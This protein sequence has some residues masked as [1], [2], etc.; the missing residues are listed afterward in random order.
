MKTSS[1]SGMTL[2]EVLV[3]F[4][5]FVLMIMALVTLANTGLD[6][7]TAGESRK[8]A[9]DRAQ[10]VL[11][12]I[13]QDLR[14]AAGEN[15]IHVDGRNELMPMALLCDYDGNRAQR[16]RFV[17]GGDME[18]IQVQPDPNA[19]L[20]KR[21]PSMYYGDYWEIAYVM[22]TDGSKNTLYR[23][24][25][26]FDRRT[27]WTLLRD[28][29]V[30]KTSAEWF[31][32]YAMVL[33]K[34]VL[35]LGFKFWTQDTVTWNGTGTKY[36]TCG[37]APHRPMVQ[38]SAAGKCPICGKPTVERTVQE[39]E[40]PSAIW[41]STRKTEASFRYHKRRQDR[42]DP[43]FVYPE[44]VQVTLVMESHA[45]GLGGLKLTQPLGE[46]DMVIKVTDTTGLPD[47]PYFV[48]VGSEWIEFE[49][50]TFDEI[51]VR[52]RGARGTKAQPHAQGQDV[53][54]GDTFVTEVRLPVYRPA[55]FK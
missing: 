50:R 32:K 1:Q 53:R 13:S 22:D 25:R 14:N 21:T 3:A 34:G 20:K 33:E 7:W 15:V 55:T 54:F 8:D 41:D 47:P 36:H 35:Y 28:Q 40:S 16:I 6:T 4:V 52:R 9:Y 18:R 26:Y 44:I 11:D 31:Q 19:P 38:R 49:D 5:I 51:K 12:Q 2:I 24:I 23:A 46:N 30:A 48:K 43:D 45:S 42:T 29:D 39:A 37:F 27:E 10:A 17:R